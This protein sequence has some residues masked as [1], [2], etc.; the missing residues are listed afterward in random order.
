MEHIDS[1]FESH[2]PEDPGKWPN[3]IVTWHGEK[4]LENPMNWPVRR[5]IR[6]T[7][8]LGLTTMGAAFASSSLSPTFDQIA[9]DY[10]VSTEV[11][12]LSLSLFVLGF[13]F[14]PLVCTMPQTFCSNDLKYF[15]S[16]PQSLNCMAERSLSCLHTSSRHLLDCCSYC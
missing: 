1:R 4:D 11:A 14:G 15:G 6:I 8:M 9:A 10:G 7:I 16:L 12:T 5:K 13:A 3:N 2:E